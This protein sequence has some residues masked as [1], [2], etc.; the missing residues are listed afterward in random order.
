MAK[1]ALLHAWNTF[2]DFEAAE[3]EGRQE[4]VGGQNPV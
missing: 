1:F 3:N 2:P 4:S